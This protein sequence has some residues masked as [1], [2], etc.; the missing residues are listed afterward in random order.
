MGGVSQRGGIPAR[1]DERRELAMWILV[2]ATVVDDPVMEM[3]DRFEVAYVGDVP[4]PTADEASPWFR[5][6]RFEDYL[7]SDA[8]WRDM[9][10]GVVRTLRCFSDARARVDA[11]IEKA[12][13]R[14]RMDRMP[15]IDRSLL[16]LGVAEMLAF[17]NPR[18][19]ATINGMVELAKRYGEATTPRFVNGI[20]DQIR[21]DHAIPFQ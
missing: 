12:S 16:R 2:C 4:P 8:H 7:P 9:R 10:P 17:E 18:P 3:V 19:K 5:L 11:A 15:V 6:V 20:L 13:P 14:W 21:R 1:E